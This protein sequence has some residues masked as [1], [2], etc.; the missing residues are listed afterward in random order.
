MSQVTINAGGIA[1]NL[2]FGSK[3]PLPQ[4]DPLT[5]AAWQPQW[6]GPGPNSWAQPGTTADN[7]LTAPQAPPLIFRNPA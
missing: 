4:T 6:R 2:D 5:G 3:N 1:M 7:S